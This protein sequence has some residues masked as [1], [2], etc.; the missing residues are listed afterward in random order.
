ML[1]SVA[2]AAHIL[3]QVPSS[4]APACAAT[5]AVLATIMAG[6][7]WTSK[8]RNGNAGVGLA[9]PEANS[10][11]AASSRPARWSHAPTDGTNASLAAD[12]AQAAALAQLTARMSHDLRTPLN[13]VIGFSELMSSET[14]G[15]LGSQRYQDYAKHI[16]ECGQT[17][18]K[19]TE[20]TLAITSALAQPMGEAGSC[21]VRP[22]RL[23]SLIDDAWSC[24]AMQAAQSGVTFDRE[25]SAGLEIFGERR[26]MRQILVNLFQ[27]AVSKSRPNGRIVVRTNLD[28]QGIWLTLEALGC[29]GG[30]QDETLALSVA[31]ALIELHGLA[32]ATSLDGE[33]AWRVCVAFDLALQ[34][35]FFFDAGHHP[36][37][38]IAA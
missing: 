12:L 21:G 4:V 19:S 5:A 38:G 17:L 11:P 7:S 34:P 16:R 28:G 13:A 36:G 25:A 37:A 24:V 29:H 14:F 9:A 32:V 6:L 27:D 23:Q 35:D 22:L 2:A 1:T 15:P 26:V 30:R 20:D 8:G 3:D 18:L 33:G 10:R 31:R